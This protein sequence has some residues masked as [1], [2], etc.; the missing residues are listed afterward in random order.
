VLFGSDGGGVL[1]DGQTWDFLPVA[2]NFIMN[3]VVLNDAEI[4]VSAGDILGR[5]VRQG[6]GRYVYESLIEKVTDDPANY[7]VS[8]AMIVH[9][10]AVWVTTEKVMFA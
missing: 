7:G 10:G 6:N 4:Y 1:F 3:Q 2:E 9:D 8:G 5:L